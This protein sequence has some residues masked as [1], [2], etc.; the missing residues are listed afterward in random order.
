MFPINTCWSIY[1]NDAPTL[2]C[3][4]P[5]INGG[6]WKHMVNNVDCAREEHIVTNIG[7]CMHT[8]SHIVGWN[9]DETWWTRFAW[10]DRRYS[11]DLIGSLT[12]YDFRSW[13]RTPK[14]DGSSF[15]RLKYVLLNVLLGYTMV[16]SCIL[17]IFRHL[18]LVTSNSLIVNRYLE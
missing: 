2:G 4:P 11:F 3:Q 16:Y 15:S 6:W 8:S 13:S 7:F 5:F 10:I 9:Y 18:L 14:F 1:C 12:L 17:Y